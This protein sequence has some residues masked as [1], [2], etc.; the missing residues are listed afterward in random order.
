M[1]DKELKIT[2]EKAAEQ[3]KTIPIE[4]YNKLYSQAVELDTR[5]KRLFELYSNLLEQYLSKK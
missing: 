1:V 2:E 4:E 5:Y 3:P